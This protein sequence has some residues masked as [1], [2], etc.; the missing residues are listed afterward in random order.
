MCLTRQSTEFTADIATG[1]SQ[2]DDKHPTIDKVRRMAVIMAVQETTIELLGTGD[3]RH[4]WI[5]VMADAEHH[6]I[7]TFH[8][9]DTFL[10]EIRVSRRKVTVAYV[11]QWMSQR[12][13]CS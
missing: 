6:S 2:A 9:R 3:D 12:P 7:E 10:P 5:D 11:C 8:S 13:V 4:K 1:V